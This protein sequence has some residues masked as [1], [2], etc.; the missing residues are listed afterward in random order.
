VLS[1]QSS[2]APNISEA[3]EV[4]LSELEPTPTNQDAEHIKRLKLIAEREG[5][6]WDNQTIFVL[7]HMRPEWVD[8]H[9]PIPIG[10]HIMIVD[11][12]SDIFTIRV[13]YDRA[14]LIDF[15][16]DY[17]IVYYYALW[18]NRT[19]PTRLSIKPE[20]PDRL[21]YATDYVRFV[22][23]TRVVQY[24]GDKEEARWSI[25]WFANWIKQE[26]EAT[27][28][29]AAHYADVEKTARDAVD[30]LSS[31]IGYRLP[32]FIFQ[33]MWEAGA[34]ARTGD[35]KVPK[36]EYEQCSI[37]HPILLTPS[38]RKHGDNRSYDPVR[39]GKAFR[40]LAS[41]PSCTI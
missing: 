13:R 25:D 31:I 35:G 18:W 12:V 41:Q 17:L 15:F 6:T 16:R 26:N 19:H 38:E 10:K 23:Q 39:D 34:A 2:A 7:Y 40:G 3:V 4:D 11:V 14:E 32:S 37:V 1:S 21:E 8:A 24:E 5:M 30:N 29:W 33:M 36:D 22:E 28:W 27:S 9:E 20:L